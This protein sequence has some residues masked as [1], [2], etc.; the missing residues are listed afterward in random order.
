MFGQNQKVSA[1][2]IFYP[3]IC[4]KTHEFQRIWPKMEK[5]LSRKCFS[6]KYFPE[7]SFFLKPKSLPKSLSGKSLNPKKFSNYFFTGD[8][9]TQTFS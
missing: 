1:V 9:K 6:I 3:R 4:E 2:N 5:S 8:K 7:M